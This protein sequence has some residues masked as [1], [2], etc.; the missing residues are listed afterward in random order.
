MNPNVCVKFIDNNAYPFDE[1]N[2]YGTADGNNVFGM[3]PKQ[4]AA[5]CCISKISPIRSI[6]ISA[7]SDIVLFVA[8]GTCSGL[9]QF[10]N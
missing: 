7:T 5:Y 6:P 9:V 8:T 3:M 1:S 4:S 10:K 2:F